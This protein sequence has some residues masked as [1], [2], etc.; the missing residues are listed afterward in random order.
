[1]YIGSFKQSTVAHAWYKHDYYPI[2]LWRGDTGNRLK[3]VWDY[4]KNEHKV[5]FC[6]NLFNT[7][8][9]KYE[10]VRYVAVVKIGENW[11]MV[12]SDC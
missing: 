5:V 8:G 7:I 12:G 4:E 9:F 2:K 6:Y 10:I 3:P 1:M 11:Y